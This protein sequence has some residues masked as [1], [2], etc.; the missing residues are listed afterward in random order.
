MITP[1]LSN[2]ACSMLDVLNDCYQFIPDMSADFYALMNDILHDVIEKR[3]S[4]SYS[5]IVRKISEA[6]YVIKNNNYIDS[7]R[8]APRI[9]LKNLKSEDKLIVDLND[10]M[11]KI[12]PRI[13]N[14]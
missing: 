12:T 7:H 2:K 11:T 3:N 13:V 5:A 4:Q 10:K 1:E 8:F 9:T 14:L 6:A